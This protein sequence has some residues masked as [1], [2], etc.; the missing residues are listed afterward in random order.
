MRR[1]VPPLRKIL[2]VAM[3]DAHGGRR[4]IRGVVGAT[5]AGAMIFALAQTLRRVQSYQ[6]DAFPVSR[7]VLI[8]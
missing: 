2:R 5:D 3:R 8:A 7:E 4:L 6:S 1:V